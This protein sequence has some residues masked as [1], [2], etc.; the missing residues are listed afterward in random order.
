MLISIVSVVSSRDNSRG[1][2]AACL[3]RSCWVDRTRPAEV[4]TPL[5]AH[6]PL[7]AGYVQASI[8]SYHKPIC[9]PPRLSLNRV[10]HI[11]RCAFLG[12]S[13][14]SA[15]FEFLRSTACTVFVDPHRRCSEGLIQQARGW[16]GSNIPSRTSPRH[17][18]L[19]H[20]FDSIDES[21]RFL[22]PPCFLC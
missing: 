8:V 21:V 1:G 13:T 14:T 3:H 11:S 7:R 16:R 12:T 6:T 5:H 15:P 2:S 18:C 19:Q 4:Q 17:P 10:R 22:S 9:P 20:A